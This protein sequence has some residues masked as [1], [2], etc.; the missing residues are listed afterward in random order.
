[1]REQLKLKEGRTRKPNHRFNRKK[2]KE[3]KKIMR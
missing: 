1:M 3:V 2:R